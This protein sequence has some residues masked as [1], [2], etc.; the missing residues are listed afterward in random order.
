[1]S[2]EEVAAVLQRLRTAYPQAG[3]ELVHDNPWQL[4]VATIL[5]AQCTDKRVNMITP[6]I[7][8]R[9]PDAAAL[10]GAPLEEVENLVRDCGLFRSKAKNLSRT[11]QR[12]AHEYGGEVPADRDVLMTLPGVGRKTA[13]VVVSNAFGQP[14]IAVDTHVFRVAHRL[15]WSTA[16]DPEAT[17]RDLMTLVPQSLWSETHHWMI[18]HGRRVCHALRPQCEPCELAA[19]CPR[20]GV[21]N[22]VGEEG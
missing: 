11:A 20:M 19:W 10:A 12:I 14:A 21:V 1:M 16:K 8:S 5:S 13:N 22:A 6:R 15:G 18:W 2:A 3:T 17:E 7:F 9:Y 4:L